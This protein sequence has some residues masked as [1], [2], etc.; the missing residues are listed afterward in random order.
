M[1]NSAFYKLSARETLKNNY[2]A[3]LICAIV[4]V[5]PSYFTAKLG[6]VAV[7]FGLIP[8]W[9]V[10]LLSAVVQ[11]FVINI[12]TVGFIR[13]LI[14]LA[15]REE[16][17]L[18]GYDYNL[19]FS[20]YKENFWG[21]LTTTFMRQLKIF[22]WSM[23]AAAPTLLAAVLIAALVPQ[24]ALE[25][26]LRQWLAAAMQP[27]DGNILLLAD[28]LER[29]IPHIS[30]YMLIW[31][32][33]TV[34]LIIPLIRKTYLYSMI[35]F[36]IAAYP[37]I[38]GKRAFKRSYDIMFGYRMRYF[39]VQLSF[40]GF[41]FLIYI[42]Y[43]YSGSLILYCLANAALMPYQYMTYYHFFKQRNETIEYNIEKY[44]ETEKRE[45]AL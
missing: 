18:S 41:L 42:V 11:I 33:S 32:A 28:V 31:L 30:V 26:L 10:R 38:S 14:K 34:L 4:C 27:S 5:V 20:G 39:L 15:P 1:Y 29:T 19:I 3:A 36:I 44:G 6:L 12:L 35:S 8:D 25:A 37:D 17:G 13:F 2:W 16:S 45:S 40:L 23:L 9:C 43:I 22:L 7:S 24:G 21:T